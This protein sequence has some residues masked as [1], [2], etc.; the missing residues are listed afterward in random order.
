MAYYKKHILPLLKE[1]NTL[2][3]TRPLL[4]RCTVDNVEFFV[5]S[6]DEQGAYFYR[7]LQDLLISLDPP[8]SVVYLGNCTSNE[9]EETSPETT[10]TIET[11]KFKRYRLYL[12]DLQSNFS[13]DLFQDRIN[14]VLE[15][16]KEYK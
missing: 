7:K 6:H 10:I 12:I 11:T 1:W 14:L 5:D 13:E 16:I 9:F 2:S 8:G 3:F 15:L 4:G